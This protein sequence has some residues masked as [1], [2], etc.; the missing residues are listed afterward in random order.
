VG[1]HPRTLDSGGKWMVDGRCA[2]AR[3]PATGRQKRVQC[4][5]GERRA[6]EGARVVVFGVSGF[7]GRVDV[8]LVMRAIFSFHEISRMKLHSCSSDFISG[9]HFFQNNALANNIP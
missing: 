1:C 7:G 5:L 9:Y 4:E 2:T 6:W 8:L 3:C